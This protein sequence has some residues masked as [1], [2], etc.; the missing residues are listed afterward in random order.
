M[1]TKSVCPEKEELQTQNTTVNNSACPF[2][3][4]TR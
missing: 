3:W 2:E 1:P 4:I